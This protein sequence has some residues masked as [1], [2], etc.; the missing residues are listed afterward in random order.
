[1]EKSPM[2]SA[3]LYVDPYYSGFCTII[4][5]QAQMGYWHRHNYYEVFLVLEGSAVHNANGHEYPLEKGSLV[6]IRPDDEHCYIPPISPEFKFTN[7]IITSEVIQKA[8][9]YLGSGFDYIISANDEHPIQRNLSGSEFERVRDSLENLMV[10]P[11]ADIDRHN[12]IFRLAVVDVLSCF[13]RWNMLRD[14]LTYP[15]WL[16]R[17]VLE[18]QRQENFSRGLLAMY[19]ISQYTPEHLCR[20]FNKYLMTTPTRFLNGI[21]LDE[22]ARRLI[23]TNDEII[24]IAEDVGFENLSH[25]YHLFKEQHGVSP[26]K[27]RKLSRS[28]SAREVKF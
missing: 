13:L 14:D 5:D 25:F 22:A 9:V 11:K 27:Y 6:L 23:Y 3:N 10:F 12:T 26:A 18:M 16:R 20:I 8:S 7:F 15:D 1:M 2:L 17:L 21:R 28:A 24:D 19:E 4:S